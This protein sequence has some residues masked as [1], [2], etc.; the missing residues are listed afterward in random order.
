MTNEDQP[1]SLFEVFFD[2]DYQFG[3]NVPS[4]AGASGQVKMLY[5]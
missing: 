5:R 2:V 4:E 3:P 1:A